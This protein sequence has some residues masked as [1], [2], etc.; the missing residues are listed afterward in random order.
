MNEH[1]FLFRGFSTH[2]FTDMVEAANS[3]W[4][5]KRFRYLFVTQCYCISNDFRGL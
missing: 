4:K 5:G 2:W 1:I 3:T